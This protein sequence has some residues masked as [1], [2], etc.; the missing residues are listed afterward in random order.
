[1]SGWAAFWIFCA[2]FVVAEARITM[3]GIDTALWQ[4][5]TPPELEIQQ[6]L[7]DKAAQRAAAL[8]GE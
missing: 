6:H 7:I 5:R 1:M 8:K 4:F 3:Q 2:V